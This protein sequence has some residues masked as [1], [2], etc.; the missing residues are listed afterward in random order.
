MTRSLSAQ[1]CP[2]T[3]CGNKQNRTARGITETWHW[4]TLH[5]QE[6]NPV[7]TL[8]AERLKVWGL[9]DPCRFA[10]QAPWGFVLGSV[11]E[12]TSNSFAVSTS[13]YQLV[14]LVE[15]G[16]GTPFGPV[17]PEA[18]DLIA[19]TRSLWA[20][21]LHSG[22]ARKDRRCPDLYH[23]LNFIGRQQCTTSTKVGDG[24]D[25]FSGG[26]SLFWVSF[27]LI[28]GANHLPSGRIHQSNCSRH[29]VYFHVYPRMRVLMVKSGKFISDPGWLYW[30]RASSSWYTTKLD[31]QLVN[32]I[33]VNPYESYNVGPPNHS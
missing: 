26:W 6:A 10:L 24:L 23:R 15:A 13:P 29:E 18:A 4:L 30:C 12:A 17:W 11:L 2:H 28:L 19:K 5:W 9:R 27:R 8:G 20:W 14:R 21:R 1:T 31:N 33:M 25:K 32:G 7:E 3:W 22:E 16:R